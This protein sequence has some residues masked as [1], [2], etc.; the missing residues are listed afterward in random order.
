MRNRLLRLMYWYNIIVTG[1]FALVILA[2]SLFRELRDAV[3]WNGFDPLVASLTVPLFI[4]I[5]VF[6]AL[7]LKEPEKGTLILKMQVAYKPFAILLVLYFAVRNAIGL[8]W[9]II[10]IAGLLV[11]LA[12][13]IAALTRKHE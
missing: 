6:C 1:G 12:G 3:F 7:S 11:Y 4:V 10:A 8:P 5:A 13:N 2:A 9:A